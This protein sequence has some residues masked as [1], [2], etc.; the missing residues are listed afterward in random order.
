[1]R[2]FKVDSLS[3]ERLLQDCLSQRWSIIQDAVQASVDERLLS[4]APPVDEATGYALEP[5]GDYTRKPELDDGPVTVVMRTVSADAKAQ[6]ELSVG[7]LGTDTEDDVA[8]Q[9][10]KNA[11]FREALREFVAVG[12]AKVGGLE[13]E[14]GP[15]TVAS[16]PEGRLSDELLTLLEVSGLLLS[17]YQA[18]IEYNTLSGD[19]R[20]NFGGS[21][22]STSATQTMIATDAAKQSAAGK[23]AMAMPSRR[24]S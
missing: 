10:E 20:K 5:L 15:I 22:L 17:L 3:A 16:G 18:A 13:D 8:R 21:L 4:G 19:L 6:A 7:A 1:M 24:A 9:V 23:A 14:Q 11:G 12:I 2:V